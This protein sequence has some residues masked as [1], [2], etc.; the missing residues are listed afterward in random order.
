MQPIIWMVQFNDNSVVKE[1]DENGIETIFNEEILKRRL[2][3][4]YIGLI[5]LVNSLTYSIDLQ[6][7][8]F[9]LRGQAF[10]IAK[11]VDGRVYDVTSVPNLNYRNGVIQFKC[12]KPMWILHGQ[13]LPTSVSPAAYNIGYK[14]DLPESFCTYKK[15]SKIVSIIKC[16]ALLSV[17]ADTF[18][19]T[20]SSSFTTKITHADG[21]TEE[22]GVI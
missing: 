7:G 8:K 19:P 2:E 6:N 17:N 10:G 1:V 14:I 21:T 5:D 3:F 4:R 22:H 20:I 15:G 11:E 13:T 16:Q 18:Q 12:S 9:I